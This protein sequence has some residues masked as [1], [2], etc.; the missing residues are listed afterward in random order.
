M[1]H[2]SQRQRAWSRRTV[3]VLLAATIAGV[4]SPATAAP[5]TGSPAAAA[6]A[7]PDA[8][9]SRHPDVIH[10]SAPSLHPEGVAYDARRDAFLV[11]SVT[12]GTV[13]LVTPYG[14][15]RTLVDDPKLVTTMGLTVD[16]RR[17][18][19][20]VTNADLGVADRST[21]DTENRLAGLGIYDLNSGRRLHYVDLGRLLP[22]RQHFAN[23]IAVDR[24]GNAY[25]TDSLSGAIY[26]VTPHGHASVLVQDDRLAGTTE[27]FGLNG[28]VLHPD[29]YLIG[30]MSAEGALVRIPLDQPRKFRRVDLSAPIGS[31]D[32]LLLSRT[33]TLYAIDNTSKNRVIELGSTDGW[34]S[35]REVRSVP[36]PDPAPTTLAASPGGPYVLTGRLDLLLSGTR[37]DEFQLRRL[38]EGGYGR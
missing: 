28:V 19:V 30:A 13:S 7:A 4:V 36:W 26:K 5:A 3:G 32:G 20:L 27:G 21:P 38:P 16:Q 15:A 33:G 6:A 34:S 14:S 12:H 11:G 25:V 37:S 18:R 24:A 1:I 2:T 35:T 8:R 31:P 22:G 9:S 17:G 23:D 10:G 29:G